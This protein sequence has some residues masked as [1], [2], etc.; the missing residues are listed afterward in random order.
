MNLRVILGETI[1]YASHKLQRQTRQRQLVQEPAKKL[2]KKPGQT[3]KTDEIQ[4]KKTDP[5][6]KNKNEIIHQSNPT[7]NQIA[8]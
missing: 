4:Q 6:L 3:K 5:K 1:F 8:R 2:G 7:E